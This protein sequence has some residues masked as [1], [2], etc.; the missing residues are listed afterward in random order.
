MYIAMKLFCNLFVALF[1][2]VTNYFKLYSRIH[3]VEQHLI[4][5][6]T[7]CGAK[8]FNRFKILQVQLMI[9]WAMSTVVQLAKCM[10]LL[11][12]LEV[13][14]HLQSSVIINQLITYQT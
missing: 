3:P 4:T 13:G 14:N 2:F 10:V 11:V 12:I 6:T 1:Y 5:R 7:F 9:F 8:M